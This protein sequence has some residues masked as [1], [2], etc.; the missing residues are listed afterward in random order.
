MIKKF[1]KNAIQG[2]IKIFQYKR[3]I[4]FYSTEMKPNNFFWNIS[5]KPFEPKISEVLRK[6]IGK[7][8]Q[9]KKKR[10]AILK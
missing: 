5:T 2:R 7:E 4:K 8:K 3:V 6:K 10:K 1:V 9:N